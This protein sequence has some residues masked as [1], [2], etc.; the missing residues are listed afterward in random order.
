MMR[1]SNFH[2][3][4]FAKSGKRSLSRLLAV[5]D[6]CFVTVGV[7]SLTYCVAMLIYPEILENWSVR[8]VAW[9]SKREPR[10]G[11]YWYAWSLFICAV[12]VV[13]LILL[14]FL[15]GFATFL[16]V[17]TTRHESR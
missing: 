9:Y 15:V 5:L 2:D 3:P 16:Y 11:D 13:V 12:I 4:S 6:I 14:R 8:I 17:A 10:S 1:D 7:A